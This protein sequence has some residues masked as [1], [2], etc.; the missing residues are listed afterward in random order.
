VTKVSAAAASSSVSL[1][2]FVLVYLLASMPDFTEKD[3]MMY[4]PSLLFL[5]TGQRDT[6]VSA[7]GIDFERER[8]YDG[9]FNTPIFEAND[10]RFHTVHD[11]SALVEQESRPFGC[12][13]HQ[14]PL[15][16]VNDEYHASS[17]PLL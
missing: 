12:T 10:E 15:M 6:A 7:A 8:L 16:P 13:G 11:R 17:F 14:R 1:R 4:F 3:G 2:E 5:H 9:T